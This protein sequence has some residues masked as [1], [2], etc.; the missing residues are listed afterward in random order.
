MSKL[1]FYFSFKVDATETIGEVFYQSRKL[2][3]IM[4]RWEFVSIYGM[5]SGRSEFS[6][7]LRQLLAL[8]GS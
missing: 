2:C 4:G 6:N 8:L 1:L 3:W 7:A 5:A